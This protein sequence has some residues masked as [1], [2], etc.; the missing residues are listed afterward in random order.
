MKVEKDIDKYI[1]Y[2]YDND[3]DIKK[4]IKEVISDLEKYYNISYSN[5]DIRAYINKYYGIILEI[6]ESNYEYFDNIN[7]NLKVLKDTLFL[8]EVDDPLDYIDNDIYYYDNK[9]YI[10]IKKLDINLIENSNII[11]G[12]YVYKIIGKGIKL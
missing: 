12:D 6:K 11:Y 9:F 10:S 7:I 3:K 4:I 1:V 8:Y 2:L 5:Y